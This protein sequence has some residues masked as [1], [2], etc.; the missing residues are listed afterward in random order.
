MA[1]VANASKRSID[2]VVNGN[3]ESVHKLYDSSVF[4][5]LVQLFHAVAAIQQKVS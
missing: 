3:N 2:I 5:V 1:N 4:L